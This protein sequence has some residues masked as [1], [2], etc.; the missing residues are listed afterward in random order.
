MAANQ[1]TKAAEG[2]NRAALTK[3]TRAWGCDLDYDEDAEK[4]KFRGE[5]P[6]V[7]ELTAEV[8]DE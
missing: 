2:A 4:D 3:S 7:E 5:E 6:S 8:V 1:I